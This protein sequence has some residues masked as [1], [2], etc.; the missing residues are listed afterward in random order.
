MESDLLCQIE[1]NELRKKIQESPEEVQQYLSALCSQIQDLSKIG[2]ALSAERNL[3]KL[4]EMI[5]E[6]ARHFTNADG[7]TLYMVNDDGLSLRFEIVQTSSLNIRMGGTSGKTIDW[8]PVRLYLQDGTPN[9]A[10]VSAHVGLSGE[11]VNIPD[12]YDVQGFDFTGTRAFDSKTGYR[13]KSMLVVPM[14]NHEDEIIGVLQLLNALDPISNE[15][16]PFT[17]ADQGLIISLASQAAVAITNTRL[18]HDLELLLESFIQVIASAIDEKSPYT[19][20]HIERVAKLTMMIAENINNI[21]YGV[22]APLFLNQDELK[23]LR[24]AS[25]M[26]DIGKITT[27]EYVVDKSTKLE[28]IY[29]RINT[30]KARFEILKRDEK[31]KLLEHQLKVAKGESLENIESVEEN[32][33]MRIQTIDD[34]LAFI[35]TANIGGEYMAPEKQDRVK[36]IGQQ[37]IE[38]NNET[39]ELLDENEILNLCIPRGTLTNE[40]REIINH[41]VVMTIK[42]L[43]KLPYPK[44]LQRVPEYAGGH[45][46]KLDGTGYPNGLKEEQLSPQAR[47]MALADIFEAL[48]ARDRPYKKGK[49][50]AEA[51]K[52]MGFMAKDKHIDP[53]LFK[54][55]VQEKLYLK[56]AQENMDPSQ[57]DDIDPKIVQ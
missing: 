8:Y 30:V 11:V 49:T 51:M 1:N 9:H 32:Y 23:E 6:E 7:G 48:T 38:L 45:H 43:E 31:I 40:E 56:Y 21:D 55:F 34:D 20:G 53:E 12:V 42:M 39:R 47:M 2:A 24:I 15:P 29:D 10:M 26:H 52:I 50:L 14:R 41:H 54:I 44:K 13:S 35:E 3:P 37:K 19:G 46:E 5:L 25:W 57:I 36:E 28:T 16:I 27:P 17:N 18:I 22:Y 33:Q 4:L